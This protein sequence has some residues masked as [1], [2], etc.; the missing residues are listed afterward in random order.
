MGHKKKAAAKLLAL[1]L[2]GLAG[3]EMEKLSQAAESTTEKPAATVE[4]EAPKT[5]QSKPAPKK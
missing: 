4:A 1:W 3:A 5:P 2:S